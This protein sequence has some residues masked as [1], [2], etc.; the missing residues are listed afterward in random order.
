MH[1]TYIIYFRQVAKIGSTSA[2]VD[3]HSK[4]FSVWTLIHGSV[5]AFIILERTLVPW[6]FRKV[7]V[8]SSFST[9]ISVK[10]VEFYQPYINLVK[11]L[12][13]SWDWAFPPLIIFTRTIA[14]KMKFPLCHDRP[15]TMQFLM[16]FS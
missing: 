16:N 13:F 10:S 4:R 2:D 15:I 14:M 7:F 1:H 12:I 11:K 9:F 8:S 5:L 6:H 3:H